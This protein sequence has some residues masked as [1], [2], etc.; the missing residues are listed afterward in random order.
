MKK[1]CKGGKKSKHKLTTAFFVNGMVQ[2][3]YSVVIWKSQ[4][5]CF[6]KNMDDRRDIA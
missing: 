4:N 5:G 1:E 3:E 2:S 6:F